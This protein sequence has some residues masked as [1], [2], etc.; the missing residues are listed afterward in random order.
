[1]LRPS[2]DAR[3]LGAR[4]WPKGNLEGHT[5]RVSH[6]DTSVRHRIT[7][8]VE[9][10]VHILEEQGKQIWALEP[11]IDSP[12]P[13]HVLPNLSFFAA[14]RLRQVLRGVELGHLREGARLHGDL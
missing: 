12:V 11:S 4:G 13:D 6:F 8:V 9:R 1:M 14:C 7:C 10:E 2:E 3:V 5:S